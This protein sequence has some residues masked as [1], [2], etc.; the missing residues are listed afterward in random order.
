MVREQGREGEIERES[1]SQKS[2]WLETIE[3]ASFDSV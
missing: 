1:N 3:G 2:I